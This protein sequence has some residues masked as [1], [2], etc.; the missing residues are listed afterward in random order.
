MATN[1]LGWQTNEQLTSYATGILPDYAALFA[2]ADFIAPRV[3]TGQTKGEYAK[4][5]DAQAFLAYS[6]DRAVSGERQR[7]KFTGSTGTFNCKPKALEIP[8]DTQVEG[9]GPQS[10][11]VQRA[12][13]RTLLSTFATS[14]LYRVFTVA[15]TS[16]NFTAATDADAGKWSNGNIDPITKID[17]VIL[18][19]YNATGVMPNRMTIDLGSWIKL[20]NNPLV[21]ARQPGSANI[22][23]TLAQL[24]AMLAVPLEVKLVTGVRTTSG[25]GAATA[26]K[27]AIHASTAMVFFAQPAPSEFDPSAF[28]TFSPDASGVSDVGSYDED[29]THSIIYK[30]D[31]LEAIEAVGPTLA[32]K[33]AV[34]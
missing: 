30:I 27:A 31:M 25:F 5:D 9:Q 15:T 8:Y 10:G 6:A 1:P 2:D 26:T 13:M 18:Q 22:G 19:I 24:S 21:T 17:G 29:K 28:K 11:L 12:K 34:T 32:V 33:I 14:R 23:V 16:G 20:K 3:V 7:I 4:F